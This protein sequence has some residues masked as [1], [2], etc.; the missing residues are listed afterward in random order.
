MS[1]APEVSSA[2]ARWRPFWISFPVLLALMMLWGLASPL[3]SSPDEPAHAIRAAAVARGDL[4]GT[5]STR[6]PGTSEV[7]VPRFIADSMH[8]TC[9]RNQSMVPAS[10]QPALPSDPDRLVTGYT[11]A[12]LNT[13]VFYVLTGIPTLFTDGTKTFYAMRAI[14]ALICSALLAVMFAALWA[15]PRRRWTTLAAVVSVTP[16]VLFLSGTVNPNAVEVAAAAATLALL[17]QILRS[18]TPGWV[19]WERILLLVVAV[20]LLVNTRS[21]SL[22]WL[23]IVAGVAFLLADT[24]RLRSVFRRPAAW[25]G[26]AG[27]GLASVSALW[28]FLVPKGLTQEFTSA[29]VGSPWGEAFLTMIDRTWEFATAWIGVFG[30]IDTP[31]PGITIAAWTIAIGGLVAGAALFA[32]WRVRV[33]L[34]VVAGTL[35]L[36]PPIVQASLAGDWG[37]VWQ[38]RYTLALV[39]VLLIVSGL[40][41]DDRF[42]DRRDWRVDRVV[43]ALV[44][45]LGIGHLAAFL[46]ALKRYTVG[47]AWNRTWVDMLLRPEWQPPLGWVSL[48]VGFTAVLAAGVVVLYRSGLVRP[49]AAGATGGAGSR[50]AEPPASTMPES[51]R[52]TPR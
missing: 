4:T 18:E 6:L 37:Y 47:I 26:V 41:L 39:P 38:G 17:L 40:G 29:G 15:L 30:W 45:L 49:I 21:L 34:I 36:L 27:I 8:L 50:A 22:F 28:W 12:T 23:V 44:I 7:E 24:D 35:L 46:W 25:V 10:C 48:A 31:A 52:E 42:G 1:Q 43:L 3:M 20:F 2:R 11:T 19:L 51:E 16:M 9:Y 5:L 13:P 33:A 32:G 14:V